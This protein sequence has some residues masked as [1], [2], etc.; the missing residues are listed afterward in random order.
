M[1]TIPENNQPGESSDSQAAPYLSRQ[2]SSHSTDSDQS[3]VETGFLQSL[4]QD[5]TY[6]ESRSE[7]RSMSMQDQEATTPHDSR[8]KN[9]NYNVL[10]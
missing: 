6:I 4:H 10:L 8:F 5:T 3:H 1:E 7:L 2:T 9:G